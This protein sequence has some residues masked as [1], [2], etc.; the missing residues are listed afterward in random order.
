MAKISVKS[1]TSNAMQQWQLLQDAN[2]QLDAAKRAY[3]AHQKS[4]SAEPFQTPKWIGL[5]ETTAIQYSYRQS[6]FALQ[7]ARRVFMERIGRG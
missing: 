5:P 4:G 6:F 7:T 1:V 2:A 3:R